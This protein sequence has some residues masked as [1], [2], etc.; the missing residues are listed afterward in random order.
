MVAIVTFLIAVIKHLTEATAGQGGQG[1]KNL[2]NSHIAPEAGWQREVG[3][4]ARI[5]FNSV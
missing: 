5:R 3:S 1:P 2:R 4:S